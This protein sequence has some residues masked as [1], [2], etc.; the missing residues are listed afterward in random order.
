MREVLFGGA[1]GGG[2][3][4][5]LLMGALQFFDVPGYAALIL[6]TTSQALTLPDG[7]V[8]RS[9]Q[10]LA[11]TG[12]TWNEQKKT[13]ASECGATL[14]FGY[15]E[16]PRDKYRY[17]SSAYQF[18]GFEELTEF[19]KEEDYTFLFSR[20][21]KTLARASLARALEDARDDEPSGSGLL[22]GQAPLSSTLRT[23]ERAAFCPSTLDD[24]PEPRR[25]SLHQGARRTGASGR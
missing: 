1:T 6:R 12:A 19:R 14:T 8:P 15:L 20:L 24:K 16:G 23:L 3:S 10:W 7:L 13:W 21:R 17:A 18:I 22:V 11:N 9:H 25:S 2:K 5:A 4:S